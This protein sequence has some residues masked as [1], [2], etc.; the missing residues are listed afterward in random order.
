MRKLS[1]YATTIGHEQGC[2]YVQYHATKIVE[3]NSD[4]I[5]LRDGGWQSVTTKRKMNQTAMMFGLGFTVF[6]IKGSWYVSYEGKT[7]GYYSGMRLHRQ[8]ERIAA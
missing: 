3:W 7:L 1:N 8:Q 2:Q 5:V 4:V 6:Q